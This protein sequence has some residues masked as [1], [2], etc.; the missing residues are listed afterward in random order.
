MKQTIN[1][2][3][4]LEAR[5]KLSNYWA[6]DWKILDDFISTLLKQQKQELKEK[7][8]K[9][10]KIRD[11]MVVYDKTYKRSSR[12]CWTNEILEGYNQAISDI[13]KLL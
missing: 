8:E 2:E 10:R 6:G 7:I 4:E 3:W 5:R 1:K 11:G 12:L 9:R 13:L